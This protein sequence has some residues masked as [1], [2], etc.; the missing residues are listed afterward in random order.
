MTILIFLY[1]VNYD[2][3]GGHFVYAN[4]V[5]TDGKLNV[6]IKKMILHDMK[7]NCAK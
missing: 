6:S 4:E 1:I 7:S 3:S 5:F 2:L